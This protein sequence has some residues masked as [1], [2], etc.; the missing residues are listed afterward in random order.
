MFD[1][2]KYGVPAL[3][4]LGVL[5]QWLAWRTRLPAIFVFLFAGILI[6]PVFDWFHPA[7]VF[8][9]FT[10]PLVSLAAAVVLFEGGMSVSWQELKI[11]SST[12]RR[13]V[14]VG[15]LVTWFGSSAAALISLGWTTEAA[16]LIGSVLV[17]T[18][19]TVVGPLLREIRLRESLAST[20][21]LEGVLNDPIGALLA[22]VVFQA[23]EVRRIESA[24]GAAAVHL[25]TGVAIGVGA[26][27]VG[28]RAFILLIRHRALPSYL[29]NAAL[30]AT[31]MLVFSVCQALRHE[32]GLLAVTVMGM[33]LSSQ[34]WVKAKPFENFFEHARVILIPVLFLVLTARVPRDVFVQLNWRW[35]AFAALTLFVV[36]PMAVFVSTLGL[37]IPWRERLFLSVVAPRGI[38]AAAVASVFG[39]RL[40]ADG[41]EEGEHLV[42]VTFLLILVSGVF[43]SVAG[44]YLG[45][46]FRL[47]Y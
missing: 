20:L 34:S 8:D 44:R 28:A 5:C 22:I 37:A 15:L 1:S 10:L 38:V 42:P 19:P 29:H 36:R 7:A 45:K 35:I 39:L 3:L 13:L 4:V 41:Y 43:S 46:A 31:V 25:S 33:T 14:T 27:F 32:S 17:V 6:G 9:D 16:L 23:L 21:R 40:A 18:G 26:G 24:L 12:V 11:V 30:F 47:R 2:I